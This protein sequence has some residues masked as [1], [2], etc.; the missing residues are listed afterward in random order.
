MSIFKPQ[1]YVGHDALDYYI[2]NGTM[3]G[4]DGVIPQVEYANSSAPVETQGASS[5]LGQGIG[6][7]LG[8]RIGS[9]LGQNAGFGLGQGIG[10]TLGQ[11]A[12]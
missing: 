11:N 1:S 6:S 7:T 2:H 3:D 10:S 9:T 4:F 8:Q 12:N 5:T